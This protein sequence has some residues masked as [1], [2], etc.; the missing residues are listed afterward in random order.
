[1]RVVWCMWQH[2]REC[3]AHACMRAEANKAAVAAN[4]GIEVVVAA[5]R[6]HEDVADVA[7]Y[8]CGALWNIAV[9]GKCS[10]AVCTCSWGAERAAAVR[11]VRCARQRDDVLA[12]ALVCLC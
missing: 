5:M 2:T 9:L 8:G 11:S 3:C 1:M 12:C 6:R 7:Q 4:G 10:A